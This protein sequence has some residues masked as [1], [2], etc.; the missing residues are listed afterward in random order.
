MVFFTTGAR[1]AVVGMTETFGCATDC[2]EEAT[3]PFDNGML[4]FNIESFC[5]FGRFG[6]FVTDFAVALVLAVIEGVDIAAGIDIGFG[7]I[8]LEGK[9]TSLENVGTTEGV[10]GLAGSL[11]DGGVVVDKLPL[12]DILFTMIGAAEVVFAAGCKAGLTVTEVEMGFD[13]VEEV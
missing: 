10:A 13:R 9:T 1:D 8:N 3:A 12:R 4:V 7:V 11:L 5:R 2:D 6:R